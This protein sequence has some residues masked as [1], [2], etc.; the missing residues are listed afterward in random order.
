MAVPSNI[1]TTVQTYQLSGLA[2]LQNLGCFIH[3]ANSKFKNFQDLTA[4]LGSSVSFDLPPR[5]TTTNSLVAAFQ[6]ADQRVH[7]LTVDKQI[8]TSYAFTD[9]EFIFN[10]KDYMTR[11]GKSAIEEIGTNVESSVAENCVSHTYRFYGNGVT[12]INS[13][14]QL[15]QALAQFRN[16]G[17]V[18]AMTRGYLSDIAVPAIVG[19][20]LNQFATT[21]N[22][23]LANSWDIGPF[24][25]CDWYQS[26]LLPVHIAGSEG[27]AGTTLTVVSATY[28]GVGGAIDTITFSGTNAASDASS[29][30]KWDKFEFQDGVSGKTNARYLTFIGHK[31]SNNRVQFRAEAN[32]GSTAGSQVTVTIYPQLQILPTSAQ[33]LNTAI[34]PGMQ[35]KVLPS[36]RAGMIASGNPLFL[37][38]PQLPNET[39]FPTGNAYDPDTGVSIRQYYGSA[40]GQNQRG[41]VH[42]C[43]WGSSL[44][45]E[46]SMALIFPL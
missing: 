42:D 23:E 6:P 38:M 8:S 13:F 15:A 44:V 3:T 32:A 41:F 1:L 4:N 43:I 46:Y 5:F 21:R 17:A 20:G 19:S 36:H 39:P 37:A 35:V 30:L 11:F 2:Y 18:S 29:V 34:V 16:Y 22:N 14:N 25:G 45:D 27:N 26:N 10:V 24:S 9:Q 33:N 7:V 28:N 31:T 40:F 12:P